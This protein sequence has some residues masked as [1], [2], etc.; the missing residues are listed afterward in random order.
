MRNLWTITLGAALAAACASPAPPPVPI[1]PVHAFV[2]PPAPR[3]AEVQ[4]RTE[5]PDAFTAELANDSDVTLTV[6]PGM[7]LVSTVERPRAEL[8]LGPGGQFELA[9][10]VLAKGTPVVVLE[11][12]GVWCK[13]LTQGRAPMGGWAHEQALGAIALS[14]A[15]LLL[16]ASRLPTVLAT[17]LVPSVESYPGRERVV[18]AIPRG[19]LFRSLVVGEVDALVWLPETNSVM[20]ISRKDVQ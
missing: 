8:R 10:A 1:E 20:W 2:G 3:R 16:D 18:T 15:P 11:Q 6:P 12:V 19:A 4:A 7:L 17:R 13:V 9:D 14:R 5:L